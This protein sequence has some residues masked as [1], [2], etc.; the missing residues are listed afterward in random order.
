MST[1]CRGGTNCKIMALADE[2]SIPGLDNVC[3]SGELWRVVPVNI[4]LLLQEDKVTF[5]VVC[6]HYLRL[7]S[8]GCVSVA[9]F[10]LQQRPEHREHTK[11]S[12]RQLYASICGV[13]R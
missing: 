9:S 10:G 5:G 2:Q 4:P 3:L 13:R 7:Q 1:E 8:P 11:Q 6:L 12:F